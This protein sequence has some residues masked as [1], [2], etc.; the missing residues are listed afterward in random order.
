MYAF[1][2]TLIALAAVS[3]IIYLRSSKVKTAVDAK[4]AEYIAKAKSAL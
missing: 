3:V 1:I 2:I 4:E